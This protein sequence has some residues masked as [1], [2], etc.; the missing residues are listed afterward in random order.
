MEL[1]SMRGRQTT[2]LLKTSFGSNIEFQVG[3]LFLHYF[4]K[5]LLSS[6][7][8]E[9]V[10]N[11]IFLFGDG[12]FSLNFGFLRKAILGLKLVSSLMSYG[13]SWLFGNSKNSILVFKSMVVIL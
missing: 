6:D 13:N 10:V 7:A 5:S 9:Y 11:I 2:L 4:C 3:W 12:Y 8:Q 1:C